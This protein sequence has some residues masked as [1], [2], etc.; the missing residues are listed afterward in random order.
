MPYV[1]RDVC[2]GE[3]CRL[4]RWL[5]CEAGTV[6]RAPLPDAPSAFALRPG[7]WVTAVASQMRVEAPGLLV[8]VDT[9]RF[10][11]LDA[12]PGHLEPL[13][14]PADTLYPLFFGTEEGPAGVFWFRG[15]R[16]VEA[17]SEPGPDPSEPYGPRGARWVRSSRA[18]WW[19]Q[20]RSERGDTGWVSLPPRV[21]YAFAGTKPH[22]EDHPLSCRR[23]NRD[24]E[25]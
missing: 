13:Y 8:F 9:V 4:G 24:R 2:P 19:V 22:Y 18:T 25:R 10:A 1:E 14:T 7:E 20:V 6:R 11:D 16:I 15:R 3:G 5:V 23:P 12:P 17:W 21:G